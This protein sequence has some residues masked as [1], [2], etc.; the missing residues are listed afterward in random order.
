M[1]TNILPNDL[2]SLNGIEFE[3]VCQMLLEKMG[4]LVTTTKKS[5]DGGID[6]MAEISQPLLS[7][8]YIVQCK[9]Y[10]GSVGEPIIRDLFGV[11]MSERANKGILMTTGYFTKSAIEFASGKPIELIDGEKLISLFLQYGL[12]IDDSK[13]NSISIEEVFAF[14][15]MTDEYSEYLSKLVMVHNNNDEQKRAEIINL[16]LEWSMFE[17]S[18]IYDFRHKLVIYKEIKKHILQYLSYLRFDKSRYLAYI[19]QMIY[20]Q[21]SIL[22]G[23]FKEAVLMFTK[24]MENDELQ[25][26][27][28]ETFDSKPL[29]AKNTKALWK[30]HIGVF[31]CMYYTFYDMVQLSIVLDDF[32]LQMQLLYD[33]KYFGY[34]ELARNVMNNAINKHPRDSSN[35]KYWK[36]ELSALDNIEKVNSLYLLSYYEAKMYYNYTYLNSDTSNI[37][38]DRYNVVFENDTLS[39][40]GLGEVENIQKLIEEYYS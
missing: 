26:T 7:G 36:E 33:E 32:D 4:F 23:N 8:K 5:G 13:N 6:L 30:E 20:I 27:I 34:Q 16:L 17:P 19:Y 35:Y 39:I 37:T 31:W 3:N 12:A 18:Q 22:E 38:L 25:F 24:L 21:L 10:S 14:Y 2:N 15:Y 1:S 40:D 11:V 29:E 9:R 28:D